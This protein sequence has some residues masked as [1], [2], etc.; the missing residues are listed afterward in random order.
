MSVITVSTNAVPSTPSSGSATIYVDSTTKKLSTKDDAGLVTDYAPSA[1]AISSLT[2]EVTAA[3]PGAA[4]ATVSN[5]AVTG[6]VLTGLSATAGTIAATD[7]I[8]QAFNKLV[9]IG[10]LDY[11]GDGSD[12]DVTITSNTTLV[13]D[14]YYNTLTINAGV[15]L[16]TGGF[17]IHCLGTMNVLG[18]VDRSGNDAVGSVAGTG[19][20]AGTTGAAGGGGNGGG[21]GAGTAGGASATAAGGTSGSGGT[22]AAGA[23]GAAGTRT[24]VTTANGGIEVL[25]ASRQAAV[26]RDLGNTV[27]TGGA[28]GG[29]GGGGG[30]ANSGGGG[31]GGGG[32]IVIN[33]L[34]LIGT[35]TIRANGGS[36]A[37]A[38]G[39]NGGGGGAGG[40]GVVCLVT[41]NVVQ[42]GTLTIQANAGS[43]GTGN[44]TGLAGSAGSVGNIYYCR[45]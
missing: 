43:A 29:G 14:M 18:T 35:G 26:A 17:R 41:R 30:A 12:G 21:A 1:N 38:G 34:N 32:I 15:I 39:V 6:K 22:G 20:T 4:T 37:A 16:T 7:T 11:F 19:L 9:D 25:K 10:S 23:G 45:A 42:G 5:S 3:G 27:I 2:G 44:G 8:L 33:A 28:G 24:V 13:R 31:G 36:G 40:G